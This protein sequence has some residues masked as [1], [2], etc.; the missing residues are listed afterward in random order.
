MYELWLL[1]LAS[2][3]L[4]CCCLYMILRHI[5][6]PKCMMVKGTLHYI[7]LMLHIEISGNSRRRQWNEVKMHKKHNG[8]DT[9][10]IIFKNFEGGFLIN[11]FRLETRMFFF[12]HM[13]NPR[14]DYILLPPRLDVNILTRHLR[15]FIHQWRVSMGFKTEFSPGAI[16]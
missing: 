1:L 5:A 3:H 7:F 14:I 10:L 11:T 12:S 4:S 16:K 2:W 13:L 15:L 6:W 8:L 9:L